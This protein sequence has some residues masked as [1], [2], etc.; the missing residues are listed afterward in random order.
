MDDR[1]QS[2]AVGS[3]LVIGLVVVVVGIAGAAA[4]GPLTSGTD[5]VRA[6]ITGDI[7]TGGIDISHQGGDALPSADLRLIVRVNGSET[8]LDWADGTL[9]GGD[10]AFDPGEG[11]RVSRDYHA[12]SVVAVTLIHEPSNTILFDTERSPASTDPVVADRGGNLGARDSEGAVSGGTN[13]GDDGNGADESIAV[14][15][16]DLTYL[17]GDAPQFVV[18]YD[19]GSVNDSFDRVEVEF[20][21]EDADDR[22]LSADRPRG[23]V[24]FLGDYGADE[25]YTI[26]IRTYDDDGSV[27]RNRTITDRADTEDRFGGDLSES[28]SPTLDD[29][30]TITDESD[31]ETDEVQYRFDY[32]VETEGNF[33]GVVLGMVNRNGNGDTVVYPPEWEWSDGEVATLDTADGEETLDADYRAETEYKLTILVFDD[34]GAVVDTLRVFDEADGEGVE[35]EDGGDDCD[36]GDDDDDGDD[37]G[38]SGSAPGRNK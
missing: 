15:V 1:A 26:T 35:C 32:E 16:N 31:P 27:G 38:N 34:E 33:G 20:D 7:G 8:G 22:T 37:P 5:T 25:P 10:D 30:T 3:I 21:G 18:S 6:E 2:E 29:D 9:S 23:S 28:D 36:E 14:G 13:R 17:D 4:L 11:W 24:G 19:V 12:D